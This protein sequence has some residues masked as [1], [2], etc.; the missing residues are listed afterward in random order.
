LTGQYDQLPWESVEQI[1]AQHFDLR[2]NALTRSLSSMDLSTLR[3]DLCG[4]TASVSV[5]KFLSWWKWFDAFEGVIYRLPDIWSIQQPASA[6]FGHCSKGAA[7][8]FLS[9]KPP[10]TFL[11]RFSGSNPSCIAVAFVDQDGISIGHVLIHC[12]GGQYT[13]IL[14]N[15]NMSY[16]TLPEVIMKCGRFVYLYPDIPKEQVFSGDEDMPH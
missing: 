8:S 6:I 1:L 2:A 9:G 15:A 16:P 14:K 13:I 3:Q 10:G 7:A 12:P 5:Q 11:L 4:H